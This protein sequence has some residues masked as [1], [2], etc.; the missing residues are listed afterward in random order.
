MKRYRINLDTMRDV[1][2]FVSVATKYNNFKIKLT[3][4]EDYTVNG[5]SLL[6]AAYTIEWS[7]VYCLV[8][9]ECDIYNDIKDFII[10]ENE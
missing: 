3:D 5:K 7:K 2:T 8:P 9:D 10:E 6:G 4:G 1:N